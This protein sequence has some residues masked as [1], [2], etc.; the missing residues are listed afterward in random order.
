MSLNV[1]FISVD[2]IKDRS[3]LHNNLDEK[4]VFPEIKAA[5]D[6]YILP[7]LGSAQYNRLQDGITNNNL[8]GLETTLLN[9]YIVDTLINF[10]LSELPQGISYQFYNKGLLRKTGDNSEYPSMQDMIDV[11]NR[12]KSRAEFYKQRLIKYLRE[13]I[14]Q[15][16]LYS[17]YGSGID[18][19]KPERD[20]YNASIWLGEDGCCGDFKTYEEKYQGNNPNCC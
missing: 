2:T 10:V 11:A 13:N 18:A 5:Q 15:F 6:I 3:G 1:L 4:L 16:P 7:A 9:D 19:I 8:T 12:Y 14:A 20:A 17:N